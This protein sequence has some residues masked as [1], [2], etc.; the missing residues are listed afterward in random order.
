MKHSVNSHVA[1]KI[2]N[3]VSHVAIKCNEPIGKNIERKKK[4][5]IEKKIIA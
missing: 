3:L 5:K 1:R 2:I 4:I